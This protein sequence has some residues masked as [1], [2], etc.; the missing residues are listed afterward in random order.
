MGKSGL[1]IPAKIKIPLFFFLVF[2]YQENMVVS[3]GLSGSLTFQEN[4]ALPWTAELPQILL[5]RYDIKRLAH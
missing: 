3:M 4:P 1:W 2:P 5:S